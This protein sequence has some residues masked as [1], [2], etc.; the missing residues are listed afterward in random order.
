[1][2]F[3]GA[4]FDLDGVIS[5]T[6]KVHARAWKQMFDV[7]LLDRSKSM[8]EEF[9]SF[10]KK[11][12]YLQYVDGKPRHEGI[13][14]FLESRDIFSDKADLNNK[15]ENKI[16]ELG[17]IKDK[18]FKQILSKEGVDLYESSINLI[19]ELHDR[20]INLFVGSS[21]KNCRRVLESSK[22]INLFESIFDGT[23][24]E[25]ENIPGKPHPGL[26]LKAIE[27]STLSVK[28]CVVFEDSVAGVLSAKGGEFFTVG[29]DRSNNPE[30]LKDAGADMIVNDLIEIDSKIM[31]Y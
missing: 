4:V 18:I 27:N 22:I 8:G 20:N 31:F 30:I 13:K 19:H 28:D 25:K 2:K 14:S 17:S 10:N 15:V 16:I 7:F 23:D 9:I 11:D 1:M 21:S 24:L 6:E 5:K 12:D 3:K 26:F 29:V